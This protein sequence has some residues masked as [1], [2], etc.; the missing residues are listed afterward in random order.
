MS[1]SDVVREVVL[2]EKAFRWQCL[3][4]SS[5]INGDGKKP[6]PQAIR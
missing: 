6:G 5:E 2:F 4:A 1:V 3:T